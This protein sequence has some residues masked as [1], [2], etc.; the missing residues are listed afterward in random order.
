MSFRE[1]LWYVLVLMAVSS[2]IVM[3]V[4]SVAEALAMTSAHVVDRLLGHPA[5]WI[6]VF[7]LAWAL[8]PILSK[9]LPVKRW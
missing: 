7:V 8:A 3:L 6:V 4:L 2:A 1:R 5:Y 9:H